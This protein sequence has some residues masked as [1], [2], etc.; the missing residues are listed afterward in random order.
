MENRGE[1]YTYH[2]A[3]PNHTTCHTIYTWKILSHWAL[4]IVLYIKILSTAWIRKQ[5]QRH[6]RTC[7]VNM[8][9]R[10]QRF[11]SKA[12]C[13]YLVAKSCLTPLQPHGCSPWGHSVHGVLQARILEWVAIPFFR[14]S[15]QSRDPTRVSYIAGRFFTVWATRE[16]I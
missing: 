3:V 1:A 5:T 16:D 12:Y 11:Q 15:S 6:E 8:G 2:Y 14:G 9:V 13:R 4:N 7:K 10:K